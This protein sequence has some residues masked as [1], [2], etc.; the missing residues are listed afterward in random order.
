MLVVSEERFTFGY[1]RMNEKTK[2]MMVTGQVRLKGADGP[3]FEVRRCMAV[4]SCDGRAVGMVA[5]VCLDPDT[6]DV[7]AVL[8]GRLPVSAD[9]RMIPIGLI[10]H[11]SEDAVH[12]HITIE[13]VEQLA[14]LEAGWSQIRQ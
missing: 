4:L 2:K 14:Q 6:Q 11:V 12:L 7:A 5:A 8:L 9:Y 10:D 1:G 3:P 13:S